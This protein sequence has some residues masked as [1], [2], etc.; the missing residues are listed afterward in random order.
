[1][2]VCSA[3]CLEKTFDV[4]VVGSGPAGLATAFGCHA[5]GLGV[6]V[7]EAGGRMAAPATATLG[8]PEIAAPEWHA[9]SDLT[10]CAALGG[11]S[12]WWGGRT[13]PLDPVD[14]LDRTEAGSPGWPLTYE[15]MLPWWQEA[16]DILGSALVETPAPGA[17]GLLARHDALRSESWGPEL[18][19]ARAWQ[20][21]LEAADGP[22]IL[23]GHRVT[24]LDREDARVTGLR[25]AGGSI[26]R[27]RHVVLACGGL[28]VLRLMLNAAREH[29]GWLAGEP[30]LGQ[31][32]M[33]HLTGTI[34]DL[35]PKDPA[36]VAAFGCLPVGDGVVARRRITPR[37]GT[38]EAEGLGNIAF[39]L[40]NPPMGDPAHGSGAISA[41]YLLL[42]Q[43][44]L[45][46]RLVAEGLRALALRGAEGPL[47]PHLRNI[48]LHPVETVTGL[49]RAVVSR[50]TDRYRRPEKLA[51]SGGGGWRL[52]YHAEQ[53]SDPGNR[54]SLTEERDADGLFGL[55]INYAFNGTDFASVERAHEILDTDLRES[56]AGQLRYLVPRE[57]LRTRI[58]DKA[59]DGYHQIG[60][61]RMSQDA[62]GGVVGPDCQVHGVENL[63]LASS[64]TFPS[65]G[66]A[67][68]TMTITALGCR[69]ANSLKKI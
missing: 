49:G 34:A 68:P 14:F 42:R 35:V 18:N 5:R 60:G 6:L 32:Y 24:G 59:S 15:D 12:H 25:L 64:S 69:V 31:G 61:T 43:A 41:K 66:Q 38:Q 36:D 67:N 47:G 30:H 26:A 13:M 21:R 1:M 40:D 20:A 37:A 52:H 16:A 28:G 17:F 33:G 2:P 48:A 44:G 50:L 51:S 58:A 22:A 10:S 53:R 56:G 27:A 9:G 55:R 8:M 7:I 54:V 11:T 23:L 29:P 4:C 63:W 62:T 45:G 39:W 3:D 46:R 65:A 57:R 19:L